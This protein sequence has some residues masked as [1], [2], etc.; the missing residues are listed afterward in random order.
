MPRITRRPESDRGRPTAGVEWEAE[1]PERDLRAVERRLD[2][3]HRRRSDEARDEEIAR[4]LVENLGRVDL[5]DVAVLH[6]RDALAQRHR[7]D[8]VV[9]H[10]DRRDSEPLVKLR[11]GRAHPDA[12][13]G[14]EVRERFVHE[15]RLRLTDDRPP[16]RDTLP[17]PA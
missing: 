12:E 10:V 9:G 13:L 6:H 2:E 16:H 11:E 7:L 15:E 1:L 5:Q 14:V 8:L 4:V 3:V 17:L